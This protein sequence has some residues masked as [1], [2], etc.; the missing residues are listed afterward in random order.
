MPSSENPKDQL[1]AGVE[2]L[3]PLFE[4]HGFSFALETVGKGSGGP[5]ASGILRKDDRRVE[6]RFR[7]YLGL[8][9]YHIKQ[10]TLD[11]ET[12]MRLLGV[13]GRN[14]YPD[15]PQEPVDSFRHLAVDLNSYCADFIFGDGQQFHSLAAAFQQDP[16]M[17]KGIA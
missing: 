8:V 17:F 6:L 14:Q 3:R 10:E 11:H 13:Y 2:I 1:L 16:L 7:Y 9:R 4:L 15:F 12:Y 5:F